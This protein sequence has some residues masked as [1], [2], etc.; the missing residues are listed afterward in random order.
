MPLDAYDLKLLALLQADGKRPQRQLAEAVNLSPSAVN[1]RIAALEAQGVISA[2]VAVVEPVAVQRPTTIVV[3]V[4]LE[5]ERID[6][7]DAVRRRFVEC[8]Q[9]QQVYY[10]TGDF[11]FLLILN[12]RDMA[13]YEQ[14]TRA[15]FFASGNVKAFKTSV[16]MQRAKVSLAVPLPD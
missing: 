9:V 14:L 15:L 12:V 6:L 3:Q 11:D 10:V 8:P 4:T 13:E 1:R 7:L 16:V 5:N 2:T